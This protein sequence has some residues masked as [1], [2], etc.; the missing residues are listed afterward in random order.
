[1]DARLQRRP[2]LG[3]NP[4]IVTPE[5]AAE[6]GYPVDHG[7][8]IGGLVS[9][10][11]AEASGV[12]KGDILVRVGD[13]ELREW[14]S[15]ATALDPHEAGDTVTVALWRD[16]AQQTLPVTLGARE[17]PAAPD[18]PE[19]VV[20]AAEEMVADIVGR[21][22]AALDGV[23]DEEAGARPEPSE[24]SVKEVLAHLLFSER[25]SVDWQARIA[26]GDPLPDWPE[27]ADVLQQRALAQLPLEHL[28]RRYE[29]ALNDTVALARTVVADGPS[30]PA[31]HELAGHVHFTPEHV[32]EHIAQIEQTLATVRT[33]EPVPA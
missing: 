30:A 32:D 14:S 23:R 2:M 19:A 24:W 20:R 22:R 7:V 31:H 11:G 18:T 1:M 9:G 5:Q 12:R 8:R 29:D 27:K 4:E 6:H 13:V 21:L 28:V 26:V 16:G 25:F 15:L 33:R 3:I 10:G 17:R